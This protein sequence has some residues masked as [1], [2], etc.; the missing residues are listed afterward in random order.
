MPGGKANYYF[1][2]NLAPHTQPNTNCIHI[3]HLGEQSDPFLPFC[4]PQHEHFTNSYANHMRMSSPRH[5]NAPCNKNETNKPKTNR[6]KRIFLVSHALNWIECRKVYGTIFI[7]NWTNEANTHHRPR[8]F[9][10]IHFFAICRMAPACAHKFL[11]PF[12]F[13]QQ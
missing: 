2:I 8:P 1:F 6:G 5:Q 4:D 13:G 9:F 10:I 12:F 11:Q 3:I 7:G